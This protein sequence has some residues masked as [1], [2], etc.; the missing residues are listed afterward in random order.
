[1]SPID[2][3]ALQPSAGRPLRRPE[4]GLLLL[5][6]VVVVLAKAWVS[7]DAYITVRTVD[8]FIHGRGL[9]WNAAERVQ[10]YTHPLWMLTLSAVCALTRE[11]YYTTMLLGL[12][13]SGLAVLLLASRLAACARG[14]CLGVAILVA[15]S[16]FTDFSTSGLENPLTHL[17]LAAFAA[18]AW[19]DRPSSHRTFWL[20]FVAALGMVNRLD[21]MLL[22]LPTLVYVC[23]RDRW[24]KAAIPVLL[25]FAP[26]WLW[27][28]FSLLYYGLLVPNSALAKL[29]TGIPGTELAA[30]GWRY[31][32]KSMQWDP[33][34]LLAIVGGMAVPC[35]RR[36]RSAA[37]VGAGIILHLLYVV[38]VGGDFMSGRFFT[39]PLFMAAILLARLELRRRLAWTLCV[40]A[41]AFGGGTRLETRDRQRTYRQNWKQ[42]IGADG[43][44]DERLF[45]IHLTALRSVRGQQRWPQPDAARQAGYLRLRWYADPL[46]ADL[47]RVGLIEPDE[48][49][50]PAGKIQPSGTRYNPVVVRGAVGFLAFYVGP[51]C[52]V[53]DFHALADPLLARLPMTTSDPVLAALVP[54]MANRRWRIGHF[55]RLI[56]LGYVETLGTGENRIRDP[57]LAAYYDKIA[58]ITRGRLLAPGRLAAIRDLNLHRYD[59]L[60]R[61]YLDRQRQ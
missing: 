34:T 33:V 32:V 41:L 57:S 20:C 50:P 1:L 17:L 60:L 30:Q 36:D 9:R 55:C 11:Y 31:F 2:A 26:L 24:P 39:A 46:V 4:L 12:A 23:A 47:K 25:G 14:A 15:S 29:N 3:N 43:I 18:V 56:P 58:L 35:V 51:D 10:A 5:V 8:N 53:L 7:D 45:Y 61:A 21:S 42:S 13:I 44:V 40:V 49:W 54:K 52:Y 37:L 59:G 27:E 38:R 19:G 16:A 22:V 28:G 6:F 48:A